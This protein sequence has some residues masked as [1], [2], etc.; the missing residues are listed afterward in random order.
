MYIIISTIILRKPISDNEISFRLMKKSAVH[1]I[2]IT[3]DS[4]HSRILH[5][6][7]THQVAHTV[8]NHD[9]WNGEV[10]SI[11]YANL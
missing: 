9:R 11:I 5:T 7:R 10:I 1:N 4:V 8:R 3:I 6:T 2:N